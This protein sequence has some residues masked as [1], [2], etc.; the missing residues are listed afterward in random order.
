MKNIQKFIQK[1]QTKKPV[2]FHL[3]YPTEYNKILDLTSFLPKNSPIR[4]RFW[5]IERNILTIPLCTVCTIRPVRWNKNKNIY[6]RTC[7]CSCNN[8]DQVKKN[9]AT[10][11]TLQKYGVSSYAQ[12]EEFQTIIKQIP[13]TTRKL[14]QEKRQKTTFSRYGVENYAQTSKF[15]ELIKNKALK[16]NKEQKQHIQSKRKETSLKTYG[17]EHHMQSPSVKQKVVAR[18][19]S[20]FGCNTYQ[21]SL[22]T[23]E[24]REKLYNKQWLEHQHH[25]LK[26]TQQQ[27]AKELNVNPTTVGRVL[28]S[29]AIEKLFFYGSAEQKSLTEFLQKNNITTLSNQRIL[30]GRKE[31]DIL[32]PDHKLAIEYCGLYWHCDIHP[33]ITKT[34]HQQ[35]YEEC[36]KLGYTLITIFQDEWIDKQEIV[37]EKLLFLC[38]KRELFLSLNARDLMIESITS[39][40]KNKFINENH[41]Q[42]SDK[43]N[44][45]YGLY[46]KGG[47]LVAVLSGKI[48]QETFEIT[49][50]AVKKYVNVR[51]GFSKLVN[52]LSKKLQISKI[53]TFADLRW[54]SG[55]LYNKT[56]FIQDKVLPPTFYYYDNRSKRLHRSNFMKH[57]IQHLVKQKEITEFEMCRQLNLLRIWDCGKIKFAKKVNYHG[58]C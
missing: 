28:N 18:I 46:T 36:K 7:S 15:K 55:E 23:K 51:G 47:M 6:S 58:S 44:V 26:K 10:T 13:Q 49:R 56:G 22:L 29:L 35:K 53:I 14:A 17:V 20:K 57:K 12:T 54:G 31:I 33:R 4:R 40:T 48:K 19:K 24:Q 41:I 45:M 8:N 21:Q 34:T 32:I 1:F 43:G 42:S 11:T 37:K 27:I 2:R 52:H 5:H 50:Y 16:L 9:K 25:V 30:P 3:L 38:K 39:K